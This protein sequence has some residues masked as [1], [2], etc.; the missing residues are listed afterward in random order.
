MNFSLKWKILLSVS[1]TCVAAVVV[2]TVVNVRS[3]IST[4]EAAILEDARTL[5][6]VLGKA[7]EGAITFEDDMTV[8]ASLNAL[9]VSPK[10]RAATVYVN[11]TAFATY[12]LG[13]ASNLLP[14]SPNT[15]GVES[16][17][18]GVIVTEEIVAEGK[19]VGSISLYVDYAEVDETIRDMTLNA[20]WIV[21]LISLLS[22]GLAYLI[23]ASVIKPVNVVVK[24]LR[25]ISEGEGDLTQRLPVSGSDEISELARCFNA[26]IER[27]NDI[28]SNVIGLAKSVDEGASGLSGMSEENE[29]A[30]IAQQTDIQHVVSAVNEMASAIQEVTLSVSE[31][32]DSAAQADGAAIVGKNTVNGTVTQIERLSQEI[33]NSSEVI[34]SL[35]QET[36][37]IGSVL[38]VIRGI[39]EQTNLLALNAAIEAARAGEQGRGFAVVADEVRTLASKTQS[40]TTEIQEMIERLQDGAQKAVDM[41]GA[42]TTAA[43]STVATAGE[44]SVALENITSIVSMIRDRTNQIAATSE[45]QSAAALQIEQSVNS[46]S[47]VANKTAESSGRI[48]ANSRELEQRAA[49][50]MELV[51][52][53]K[54]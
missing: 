29:H 5:A 6:Q 10:I 21:V 15:L 19:P 51:G 9:S 23:Q 32:A 24:A 14:S 39:A 50:M 28:I 36:V 42:G 31:A 8:E 18:D 1:L 26:F 13:D 48:T 20:F 49:E 35:R 44:A 40:S 53:F 30:S 4:L 25:D 45:Q 11:R 38:D 16:V 3:G 33:K 17:A 47:S 43:E 12:S 46:V 34:E 54:I 2:S 37:G 52:R 22:A 27:L 41:M 7:S